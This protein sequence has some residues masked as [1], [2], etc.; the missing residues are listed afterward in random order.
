MNIKGYISCIFC[1]EI[2]FKNACVMLAIG[3]N[4]LLFYE[5]IVILAS[6]AYKEENAVHMKI[7]L[8]FRV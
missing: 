1:I 2:K 3:F 6:Y 8:L 7:C 4:L 5:I